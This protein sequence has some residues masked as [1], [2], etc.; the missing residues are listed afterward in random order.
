M[1][2]IVTK[3]TTADAI[4]GMLEL[5]QVYFLTSLKERKYGFWLITETAKS[6]LQTVEFH[7]SAEESQVSYTDYH[8]DYTYYI[9]IITT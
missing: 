8:H 3:T 7:S 4:Y 9:I 2:I 5:T 6:G 1:Y